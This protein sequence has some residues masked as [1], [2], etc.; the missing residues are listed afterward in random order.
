MVIILQPLLLFCYNSLFNFK[1]I[2]TNQLVIQLLILFQTQATV[3]ND[4]FPYRKQ[5]RVIAENPNYQVKYHYSF[6]LYPLT[7]ATLSCLS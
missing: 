3:K 6:D 5:K 2:R 4:N 1:T 7:T